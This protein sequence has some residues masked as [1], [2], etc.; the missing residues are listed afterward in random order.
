MASLAEPENLCSPV[1]SLAG[2]TTPQY[3]Q[4]HDLL[5]CVNITVTIG[6]DMLCP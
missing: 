3:T 4:I 1:I 2:E 5:V 6:A